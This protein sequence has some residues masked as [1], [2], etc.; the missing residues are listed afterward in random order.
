[1]TLSEKQFARATPQLRAQLAERLQTI[2]PL[3][4][5]LSRLIPDACFV[6]EVRHTQIVVDWRLEGV[7]IRALLGWGSSRLQVRVAV[8]G[9]FCLAFHEPPEGEAEGDATEEGWTELERPMFLSPHCEFESPKAH[10]EVAR[11]LSLP[12]E[13]RARLVDLC[14][15]REVGYIALEEGILEMYLSDAQQSAPRIVAL[16]PTLAATAQALPRPIATESRTYTRRFECAHCRCIV[17][18]ASSETKCSRC[19]VPVVP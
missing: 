17:F 11:L 5:E 12:V 1:L 18:L 3:A 9:E 14:E 4:S 2:R 19:G 10:D 7:P 15:K 8:P 6:E 13:L 16:L